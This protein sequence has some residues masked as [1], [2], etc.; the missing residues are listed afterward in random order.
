MGE[1]KKGKVED[2]A[3]KTGELVGKVGKKGWGAVKS[4]G[5]G[6][7]KG[8]SS[9]FKSYTTWGYA[10]AALDY[11]AKKIRRRLDEVHGI[12]MDK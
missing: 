8:A 10:K 5:K 6:V 4:F 2:A 7:E 11:W 9:Y 3:E 12:N 1:E